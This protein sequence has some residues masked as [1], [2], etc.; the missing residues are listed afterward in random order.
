MV[1]PAEARHATAVD[2]YYTLY[3]VQA[4]IHVEQQLTIRQ[5]RAS[6]PC[7]LD[8]RTGNSAQKTIA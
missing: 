6:L 2:F 4:G 5:V 7:G 1:N 3:L 8:V